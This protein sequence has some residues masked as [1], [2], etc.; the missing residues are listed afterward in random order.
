[1][2]FLILLARFTVVAVNMPGNCHAKVIASLG[3]SERSG[4]DFSEVVVLKNCR[5]ELL[6]ML[7]DLF[8][9]LKESC[10]ADYEKGSS[11]VPIF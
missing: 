10:F 9:Y 8:I 3:S 5:P 7:T 11:V 1:M 2:D 6:Y 4:A